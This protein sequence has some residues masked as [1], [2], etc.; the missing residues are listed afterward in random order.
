MSDRSIA[1]LAV[2]SLA[3]R[4]RSRRHEHPP[5]LLLLVGVLIGA[6]VLSPIGWILVRAFEVP[7]PRAVELLTSGSTTRVLLNSVGLVASVTGLS[8]VVG[9]PL[10]V[11][12]VRTDLPFPRFWTIALGLPLVVPSY[13]GAF[14]YVAAFGPNGTFASLLEPL[15]VTGLPSIYGFEGAVFVLVLYVYPY[16][17]LGTRAALISMDSSLVEA[18]RTLGDSPVSAFRRATLPQILPG[19][20]AGA[21]LVA[22]YAL[23]DFGTPAIMH[24]DV[25]T[26]VIYVEYSYSRGSAA[27]LSVQLLLVAAVILLLESRISGADQSGYASGQVRPA[28]Q[29]ELG[30]WK[31]VVLAA[32]SAVVVL[33]LVLPVSVFVQWLVRANA[34]GIDTGYGFQWAYAWN[35]VY[36]AT[37]TAGA[38]VA[39]AVPI[40]YLSGRFDS[41][42]ARVVERATYAGYA[43]PGIV[44]ALALVYV[45]VRYVRGLYQ[46]LPLLVFA[47]VV[48]FLPQA[49]GTTRSSVVQVDRRLVEA[50]RTLGDSPVS[51]FRRVALP[52]ILPGVSA[53]AALVFLTTMKELPA[54]LL[55]QP[56]NFDTLVTYIWTV[57]ESGF[58]SRVAVP[59]LVLV[60][61]SALSMLVILARE[62]HET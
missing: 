27:L 38:A 34:A 33:A 1:D 54:T 46:T 8:T 50:A 58:Y 59:A 7:G 24:V 40:G 39:A 21:L 2:D 61:V 53:G 48:R 43:V 20:T 57:R 35:S 37:L 47:Y 22:L 5:P 62:R 32:C 11:A 10:A 15:G 4:V 19:I 6:A 13:L 60:G 9:V 25:F 31:P 56:S 28:S 52:L 12:T 36:A 14:A 3:D 42:V 51:A 30:R 55:L 17:F 26:R 44:V 29:I 49:V 45:G 16:V 18:A 23:S 41:P